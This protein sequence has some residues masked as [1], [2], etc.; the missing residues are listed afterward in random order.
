MSQVPT[1]NSFGKEI[2]DLTDSA[3]GREA[4]ELQPLRIQ[5]R[6]LQIIYTQVLPK[7]LP[8]LIGDLLSREVEY[9]PTN[10]AMYILQVFTKKG[11]DQNKAREY[12]FEKTDMIPAV[13]DKGTYYVTNQKL[14]LQIR[15]EISNS[16]DVL[17]ITDEG[18]R[19]CILK[20]IMIMKIGR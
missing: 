5:R 8:G 16:D 2:F 9:W 3:C 1:L 7:V 15:K 4:S 13:Y 10:P 11:T 18:R 6:K 17:E 19:S 14:T 12:I 20:S